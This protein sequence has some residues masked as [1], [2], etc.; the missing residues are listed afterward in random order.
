MSE[1]AELLRRVALFT[2]L[3][4]DEIEAIASRSELRRYGQG[5]IVYDQTTGH[6]KLYVMMEGEVLI[7]RSLGADRDMSLATFVEGETF[8]EFSLFR[9]TTGDTM[10][11]AE[12]HV[13]LLVFPG[14]QEHAQDEIARHPAIAAKILHSL[15]VTVAG[16]IR[17]TN[18]L[19][20][21]RAPWMQELRRQV[22]VD[23]LTGLYNSSYLEE[24]FYAPFD[25]D[26]SA[27]GILVL[28][29]DNF[30]AVN[31]TYGHDVG[32]KVLCRMAREVEAQIG[33]TGV[34]VR[35]QGNVLVAILPGADLPSARSRA[36]ALRESMCRL[37]LGDVV[38]GA[39]DPADALRGVPV[40]IGVAVYPEGGSR[41]GDLVR[42][43]YRNMFAAR[44][45]G[46]DRLCWAQK[47]TP[48]VR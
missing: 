23:K 12:S 29:P 42:R 37:H 13:R 7:S 39:S 15:L 21:E 40:S 41:A 47:S 35:Y 16:R 24:E 22:Q 4:G 17:R 48:R 34:A 8:G 14:G 5:E 31:D 45:R 33:A 19:V 1:I 3:T 2:G 46:G 27:V 44:N 28:K 20:A 30:K 11:R 9:E 43:A 25:A 6:G 32:D 18:R 10:A 36:A 38:P 26:P